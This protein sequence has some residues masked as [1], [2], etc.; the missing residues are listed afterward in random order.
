MVGGKPQ[1]GFTF[2]LHGGLPE[3]RAG[4]KQTYVSDRRKFVHN[5]LLIRH[6]RS[7][8]VYLFK[9]ENRKLSGFHAYRYYIYHAST[10][11]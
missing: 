3:A 11:K 2:F 1:E 7:L 9:Y 4:V 6:R 10:H 8:T 5:L